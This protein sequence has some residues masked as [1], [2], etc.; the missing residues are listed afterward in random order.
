M[1]REFRTN[2]ARANQ[3]RLQIAKIDNAIQSLG[4]KAAPNPLQIRKLRD[5][6]TA[7]EF[8]LRQ[9]EAPQFR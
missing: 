9:L 3:L 1:E 2:Q 4:T 6:K 5:Q 8:R 7:L